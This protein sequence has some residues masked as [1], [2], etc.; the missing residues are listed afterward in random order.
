MF[1]KRIEQKSLLKLYKR[2]FSKKKIYFKPLIKKI[3]K[4]TN[5]PLVNN[6]LIWLYIKITKRNIFS[7]ITNYNGNLLTSV[8]MGILNMKGKERNTNY[9]IESTANLLCKKITQLNKAYVIC[10][11]IGKSNLRK[12]R[13]FLK[14][15]I[16]KTPTNIFKILRFSTKSHNGCRPTKKRRL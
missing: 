15:L 16:Y 14:A 7:T 5:I 2:H 12:K 13:R 3:P 8:T 4:K 10:N 9:A 11:F 1:A 6:Q